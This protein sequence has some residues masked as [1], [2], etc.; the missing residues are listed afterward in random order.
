MDRSLFLC[1][2]RGGCASRNAT[3]FIVPV[4]SVPDHYIVC[5]MRTCQLPSLIIATRGKRIPRPGEPAHSG[6]TPDPAAAMDKFIIKTESPSSD[7]PARLSGYPHQVKRSQ[8]TVFTGKQIGAAG[9]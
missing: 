4:A 8:V 3:G 5:F 6:T 1:T 9:R 2:N 7:S